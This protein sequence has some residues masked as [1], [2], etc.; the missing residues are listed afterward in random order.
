M[1]IKE[2]CWKYITPT[3]LYERLMLRKA[4][5]TIYRRQHDFI[6]ELLKKMYFVY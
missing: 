5:D 2:L 3:A 4:E 1:K 6:H